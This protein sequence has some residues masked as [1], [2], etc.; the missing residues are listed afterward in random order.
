[1]ELA[2]FYFKQKKLKKYFTQYFRPKS[3]QSVLQKNTSSRKNT[4]STKLQILLTSNKVLLKMFNK[5]FTIYIVF[6]LFFH[7]TILLSFFQT[8]VLPAAFA[9][10]LGKKS[11]LLQKRKKILF[12]QSHII[13]FFLEFF[14]V[15]FI[16]KLI[17]ND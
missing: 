14:F 6:F 3:S 4:K 12:L 5:H 13:F 2:I 8:K 15:K 11:A 10:R 1:M 9:L 7:Y 17:F 16:F